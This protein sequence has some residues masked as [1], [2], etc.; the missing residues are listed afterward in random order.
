MIVV[1]FFGAPGSGKSTAALGLAGLLKRKQHNAE[2]VSEFAK[3]QVWAKSDHMLLNQNWVFANQELKLSLLRQQIDIVATDSPLPLS[4]FYAPQDYPGSFRE[5]C[6]HFF[7]Q[8]NNINIFLRRSHHYSDI[9]RIQGEKEAEAME[10]A[11]RNFM[12]Q[13]RISFAEFSSE[14]A[15]PEHV[16]S[17]LVAQG[18]V[19]P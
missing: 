13:H 10:N 14:Q 8:Y 9:G 15:E 18:L 1:N 16:Y 5:L 19:R 3:D 6:F 4:V 12:I 7:N 2:Y 17:Q 11:M